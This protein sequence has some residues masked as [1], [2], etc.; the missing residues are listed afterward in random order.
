[1]RNIQVIDG[2]DNAMY[3]IFAAT[4]DE[5]ALIFPAGQDVAFIDEVI[6]RTPVAALDHAFAAIWQRRVAKAE[7]K[8]IHGI[9]FYEMPQKKQYYPTRRDEAAINPDGT[10]LR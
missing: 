3:D 9:L 6:A 4:E 5:F 10:R 7:A 8:G 1:M 2:A